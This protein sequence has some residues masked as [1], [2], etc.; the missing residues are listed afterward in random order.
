M[1]TTA[2]SDNPNS[3]KYGR[4]VPDMWLVSRKQPSGDG[5]HAYQLQYGGSS[6]AGRSTKR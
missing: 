2:F 4:G 1:G 6:A 5:V 3:A